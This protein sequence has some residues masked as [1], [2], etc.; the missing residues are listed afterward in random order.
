MSKLKTEIYISSIL[1]K[2]ILNCIIE[3]KK[4]N[5]E[6]LK[7]KHLK[8]DI[9]ELENDYLEIKKK[10]NYK[11]FEYRYFLF[12]EM[13]KKKYS[14]K[15]ISLRKRKQKKEKKVNIIYSD[16]GMCLGYNPSL[17]SLLVF[18]KEIKNILK[19]SKFFKELQQNGDLKNISTSKKISII[20]KILSGKLK[21]ITP[22]CPDYEHVKIAFGLYKYTFNKLNEDVGL[23][24]TRLI[25]IMGK[26]HKTFDKYKIK[27]DHN[28][29][30]GDFEAYSKEILKRTKE[31]EKTFIS[32]IKKSCIKMNEVTKSNAKAYLLVNSLTTKKKFL[33]LCEENERKIKNKM[34]IDIYFSRQINEI[35]ASR[36]A[37]YSS[38]FPNY[39]E[40]EY[41]KIVIKQ[42]AEYL[43][44]GQLFQKKFKNFL[45]I[46]LDHPKMGFFYNIFDDN[47]AIY[48][49]P[50]YA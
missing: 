24:G 4:I 46:G 42:G 36:T 50:K 48:G 44:M 25:K 34:N 12:W 28:L 3:K 26:I 45:I 6:K 39:D 14:D 29:Y 40:E 15:I 43:T 5:F 47:I 21:L 41:K 23:I 2:T 8:K 22:L 10:V 31:T 38:W 11:D 37:L 19:F 33:E 27:F 9:K 32:K 1:S 20:N 16:I 13:V 18:N 35:T 7:I 49:T 17:L 30:Y